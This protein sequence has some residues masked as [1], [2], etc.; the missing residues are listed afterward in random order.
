MTQAIDSQTVAQYL[1]NHPEFFENHADIL[2]ELRL[3]SPVIGKAI[4]L[5][6]RQIEVLREKY[7]VLELQLSRLMHTA[8]D[9]KNLVEKIIVWASM[10]LEKQRHETD[11][12]QIVVNGLKSVF[13]VPEVTLRVWN[14]REEYAG[15]WFTQHVDENIRNAANHMQ[16]PYCGKMPEN[17]DA[18]KWLD[19]FSE[20]RSVALVPLRKDR[21]ALPFGLI[22]MGS[23]E[24]TR[25][26]N[27]MAT[28]FLADIGELASA[29]LH[30]L[31]VTD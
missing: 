25:F 29:T 18:V 12:P 9:N 22:A 14:I 20:I 13:T 27:D 3:T 10:L 15:S 2:P 19:R 21:Q 16:H 24:A 6:E 5:H 23:P 4:S 11:M 8:Q 30:H 31:T 26:R 17:Q 7:R 1:I 28:D